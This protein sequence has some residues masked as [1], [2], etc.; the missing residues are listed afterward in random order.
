[1]DDRN[2]SRQSFYS[3]VAESVEKVR[4]RN[5]FPVRKLLLCNHFCVERKLPALADRP[6]D[7]SLELFDIRISA[8]ARV[9]ST[10]VLCAVLFKTVLCR[11]RKIEKSGRLYPNVKEMQ[12]RR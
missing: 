8:S 9:K 12:Y 1:M 11:K 2:I 4:K 10:H 7:S 6:F 5:N 3:S